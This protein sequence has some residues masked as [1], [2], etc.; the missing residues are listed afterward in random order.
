MKNDQGWPLPP[1]PDQR[2]DI[3]AIYKARYLP[4]FEIYHSEASPEH[5]A[6][7]L[8]SLQEFDAPIILRRPAIL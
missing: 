3:E 4:A 1:D 8:V 7:F 2:A 5:A 6:D